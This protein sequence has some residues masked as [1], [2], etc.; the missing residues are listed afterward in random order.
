MEILKELCFNGDMSTNATE[1]TIFRDVHNNSITMFLDEVET[2]GK[3]DADM[4]RNII[5][6]LNTGFS[7][8]GIVKRA[9][10]KNQNFAIQ[11][12]STYSPKMF[13]G[14]KEIDD[15][16]QDRT[17]KIAMLRRKSGEVIKRYKMTDTLI[18]T[19]RKIKDE[20]YIF[21]LQYAE[22]VS[23]LYNNHFEQL[24][25]IEHLENREMDIW[26]P[27]F[28]IANVIDIENGNS[29]LTDSLSQ[30]SKESSSERLEDNKD[31]NETV[32]LLS[33][34]DEM[35]NNDTPI[36]FKTDKSIKYYETGDVFSYFKET[37]EYGWL[38]EYTKTTLTKLIKN[39]AKINSK[40]EWSPKLRKKVRAYP[41]DTDHLKDLVERYT[42]NTTNPNSLSIG[43]EK[44]VP[45]T[46]MS[47]VS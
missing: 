30:L 20:L 26:E 8:S 23:D 41:V 42:G 28:T 17:I 15:V 1:A 13:A 12:F 40:I 39:H 21:G 9:G 43:V 10:S 32:K 35:V 44:S 31:L 25:G 37:E 47:Y 24:E 46:E 34:L 45:C 6:I 14:I 3:K 2:L 4:Y 36:P 19:Q 33:V 7:N 11:R 22:D 18:K 16:V 27:I 29:D 38:V 5:S